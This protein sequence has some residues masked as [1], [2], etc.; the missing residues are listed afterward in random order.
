V[1][2]AVDAHADLAALTALAAQ[3]ALIA[4]ITQLIMDH[5]DKKRLGSTTG[6]GHDL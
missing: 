6:A 3:T 4:L 2:E 1:P 5:A